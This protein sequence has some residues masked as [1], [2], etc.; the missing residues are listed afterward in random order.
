MIFF[1]LFFFGLICG[2]TEINEF[3]VRG[4]TT[5]GKLRKVKSYRCKQDVG[6]VKKLFDLSDTQLNAN[7]SS[8]IFHGL[9]PLHSPSPL[10]LLPRLMP[11]CP[12]EA[13]AHVSLR[14]LCGAFLITAHFTCGFIDVTCKKKMVKVLQLMLDL[15]KS[16][17]FA[18]T[19]VIFFKEPLFEGDSYLQ[20]VRVFLRDPKGWLREIMPIITQTGLY[21]KQG[22]PNWAEQSGRT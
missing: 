9:V 18:S 19:F 2:L 3:N 17:Y 7:Q 13:T 8:N 14:V 1:R 4:V 22:V 15:Q 20:L 6:I 11:T 10:R 12:I 21:S 5:T 16:H